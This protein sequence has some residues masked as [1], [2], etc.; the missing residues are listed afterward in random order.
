M[1]T[2]HMRRMGWAYVGL[3]VLTLLALLREPLGLLLP[4]SVAGFVAG[5]GVLQIVT[6][7]VADRRTTRTPA[8]DPDDHDDEQDSDYRVTVDPTGH[9]GRTGVHATK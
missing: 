7:Y 5:I 9:A 4:I 1:N 2:A 3:G 8:V 6:A